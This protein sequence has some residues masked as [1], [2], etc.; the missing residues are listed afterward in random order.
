MV[1]LAIKA[2]VPHVSGA[3]YITYTYII[4][5]YIY[6]YIIVSLEIYIPTQKNRFTYI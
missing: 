1:V 2:R 6:I 5:I 4:H 3:L